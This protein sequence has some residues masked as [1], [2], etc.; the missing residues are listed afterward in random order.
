ML[1]SD[2][3]YMSFLLLAD[4][5][6]WDLDIT[7]DS[8]QERNPISWRQADYRVEAQQHKN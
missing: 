7:A 6:A 1:K 5:K 2:S 8:V 3:N 4:P